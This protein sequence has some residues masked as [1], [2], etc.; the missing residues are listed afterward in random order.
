MLLGEGVMSSENAFWL[1]DQL[2]NVVLTVCLFRSFSYLKCTFSMTWISI[3]SARDRF[4]K[5]RVGDYDKNNWICVHFTSF[6]HN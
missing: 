1:K 6:C 2:E 5:V 3:K 4:C